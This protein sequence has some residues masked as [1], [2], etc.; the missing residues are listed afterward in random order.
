M[1]NT[2]FD[3]NFYKML[4]PDLNHLSDEELERHYNEFGIKENRI[5]NNVLPIDFDVNAYGILN[6]DLYDLFSNHEKR[7]YKCVVGTILDENKY[8]TDNDVDGNLNLIKHYCLHGRD[9]DRNYKYEISKQFNFKKYINIYPTLTKIE[10]IEHYINNDFDE[11]SNIVINDDAL[12]ES[13]IP[14][15]FYYKIYLYLN[16]DLD[17]MNEN[18]AIKHYLTIGIKENRKY[19]FN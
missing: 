17:D 18:D 11:I 12:N 15:D 13:L 9:E 8:N 7:K 5:C 3:C 4:Y 19:N 2:K 10:I 16:K 6:K 1:D 14:D